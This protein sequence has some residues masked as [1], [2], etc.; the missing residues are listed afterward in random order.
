MLA[1]LALRLGILLLTLTVA[2]APAPST[3]PSALTRP[4]VSLSAPAPAETLSRPL[5]PVYW[6]TRAERTD[7]KLTSDYDETVRYCRQLEAGSNWVKVTSFGRSGQGRE[8]PLLIVSK[9][10]AFTPAAAAAKI[11]RAHV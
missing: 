3:T 11:G 6:R 2:A 10:R 8:L 7:Y 9:D 1:S 4:P 5:I